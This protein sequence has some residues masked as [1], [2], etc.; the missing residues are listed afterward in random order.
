MITI[1]LS[2]LGD[3]CYWGDDSSVIGREW[4]GV[5]RASIDSSTLFRMRGGDLA[6]Y[7]GATLVID[8]RVLMVIERDVLRNGFIV[9]EEDEISHALL[10][11]KTAYWGEMIRWA[12]LVKTLE[13]YHD[14]I[15]YRPVE[16]DEFA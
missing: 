10:R 1:R 2:L 11:W 13:H 5:G 7:P 9:M 4:N 16:H 8:G 15:G 14:A 6:I 3:I 12:S